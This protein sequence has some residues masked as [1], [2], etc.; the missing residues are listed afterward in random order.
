[1]VKLNERDKW[2]CAMLPSLFML[3]V[4]GWLFAR[5]VLRETAAMRAD[6]RSQ[7]PADVRAERLAAAEK[8][9][10]RLA[11]EVAVARQ[12]MAGLES[13][14]ATVDP[15]S[16]AQGRAATLRKLSDLCT[17]TDVTLVAARKQASDVGTGSALGALLQKMHWAGAEHWRLEM[18]GSFGGMSRWLAGLSAA[19]IQAL[20]T[21]LDLAPGAE[22]SQ[23]GAWTLDLW[24]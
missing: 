8:A 10:G 5:P 14:A 7:D 24:I 23:P 18:S 12:E 6:L 21:G 15:V 22:A 11:A 19:G 3:V 9:S 4:Y 2:L 1:M 13:P 16:A 20:P 17:A